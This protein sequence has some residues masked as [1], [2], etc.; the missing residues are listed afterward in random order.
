M[1]FGAA[2]ALA[3]EID[4][5]EPSWARRS[6]GDRGPWAKLGV[7]V[8]GRT[9]TRAEIATTDKVIRAVHVPLA[10]LIDWWVR[11]IPFIAFEE[12]S[13]RFRTDVSLP[14]ALAEWNAAPPSGGLDEDAWVDARY[15]WYARHFWLPGAEGAWIPNLGFVRSDSRL[16]LSWDSPSFVDEGAPRFLEAPD[17]VGV[18]WNAAI[19]ALRDLTAFVAA[20]IRTRGLLDAYPWASESDPLGVRIRWKDTD[21][22]E[23]FAPGLGVGLLAEAARK[24]GLTGAPAD[25]SAALLALR[26]LNAQGEA[27]DLLARLEVNVRGG[28]SSP[29]MREREMFREARQNPS[30]EGAGYDAADALRASLGNE[31]APLDDDA[32]LKL[33]RGR[34]GVTIEDVRTT[35]LS[36]ASAMGARPDGGATLVRFIHRF[37][38][39]TWTGRME[40]AR[41]VAHLLLDAESSE[42]VLG[43]GSSTRAV[44]PR[45]R[46]SGAFAAELL[47]PRRGVHRLLGKLGTSAEDEGA[48][49]T[50]M[51]QFG[52]GARTAAW[53]LWN[54]K[55]LSNAEVRDALIDQHASNGDS[56][57]LVTSRHEVYAPCTTGR[58]VPPA[59]ACPMRLCPVGWHCARKPVQGLRSTPSF[60][61]DATAGG[62][63]DGARSIR[64]V[65]GDR[66]EG[67]SPHGL[68]R[69]S[70]SMTTPMSG[71][72]QYGSIQRRCCSFQSGF[73]RR[74]CPRTM[75]RFMIVRPDSVRSRSR[76]RARAEMGIRPGR[77]KTSPGRAGADGSVP[78]ACPWRPCG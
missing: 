64:A 14:R 76:K 17:T 65:R 12:S 23:L 30:P 21:A 41:A 18:P 11:S 8:A 25:G 16:W 56:Q 45:R 63:D 73:G 3:F 60:R 67:G 61:R 37:T 58:V 1:R 49:E 5:V 55:F 43:A 36:N 78:G 70:R 32:L 26:D 34:L 20:E 68:I 2:D 72:F 57:A 7:I 53:H 24:L 74:Q 48:F 22:L 15:A 29:L 46:R 42:G 35:D 47:L 38:E 6:P 39:R 62:P 10:P 69:Y 13:R 31:D 40:T 44:G 66:V 54:N 71:P 59:G 33:V 51:D 4:P 77:W 19:E 52:V 28:T 27:F 9:L 75:N 50:I